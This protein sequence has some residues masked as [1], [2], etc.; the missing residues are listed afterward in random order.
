MDELQKKGLKNQSIKFAVDCFF[1]K[2]YLL[3]HFFTKESQ[4]LG[5]AKTGNEKRH[6]LIVDLRSCNWTFR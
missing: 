2:T 5:H 4:K 1:L 3:F 6:E